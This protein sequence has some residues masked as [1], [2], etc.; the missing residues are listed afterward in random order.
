MSDTRRLVALVF[1]LIGLGVAVFGV[2]RGLSKTGPAEGIRMTISIDPP[3]DADAVAVAKHVVTDRVDEKGLETRVM[4]A[5]DKL[6]VELGG[7]DAETAV[8]IRALLER[9]A[10]VDI[11]DATTQQLVLEGKR[12][13][14]AEVSRGGV[15][16]EVPDARAFKPGQS[17]AFVFE[18]KVRAT[19]AVDAATA[20]NVHV[21]IGTNDAD[22]IAANELVGMLH[23]GAVHPLHVTKVDT[24]TRATGF[25]PRAWLFLAI[26]GVLVLAGTVVALRR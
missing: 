26:G 6:V 3:I 14:G 13:R 8:A 9:T 4:P 12:V 23:A 25:L 10:K 11:L 24:F 20:T 7:A 2:V 21:T 17:L 22:F 16:I 19:H 5:G 18:G 1:A 15:A